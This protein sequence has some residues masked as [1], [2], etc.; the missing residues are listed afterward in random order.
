MSAD[1]PNTVKNFLE[2]Q[3]G[4]DKVVAAHPNVIQDEVTA[5]E[6]FLGQSGTTQANLVSLLA[7][8]KDYRDGVVCSI[9]DADE[10]Y[11]GIGAIQIRDASGNI[12]LRQNTSVLT[13][14]N[15]D[16]DTGAAFTAST[17]HYV[18]AV[19][20]NSGTTFTC[21]I[22]IDDT[23]PAGATFYR[24]IGWFMTD[25]TPDILYVGNLGDRTP[26]IVNVKGV[27]DITCVPTSYTDMADMEI[28]FV[29]N[30]RPLLV[31]FS[32][33]IATN[34][35]GGAVSVQLLAEAVQLDETVNIAKS[36]N[37]SSYPEACVL[38][39]AGILS[40]GVHTVKIQ[41]KMDGAI[42]GYQNGTNNFRKLIISEI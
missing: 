2:K 13:L 10:V 38:M 12:R 21:L 42:A 9:K 4:V 7:L 27:T 29:S 40:A 34:S 8:L 16:L 39:F 30:G 35:S 6:T 24:K 20:D 15:T 32:A 14:D 36:G 25:A 5:I 37:T 19:A 41:W 28:E 31:F 33:P 1:F 23:T 17:V 11:V 3:D 18:Y 22:S 26:N